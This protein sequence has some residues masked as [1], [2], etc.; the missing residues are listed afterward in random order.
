M[1]LLLGLMLERQ[2]IKLLG[3]MLVKVNN[4][5]KLKQPKAISLQVWNSISNPAPSR[6]TGLHVDLT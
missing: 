5:H 4:G 3:T 1:S 6:E 2:N